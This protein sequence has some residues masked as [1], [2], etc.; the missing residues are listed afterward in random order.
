[1]ENVDVAIVGGGM[2]GLSV[3]VA[4]ENSG[5]SVAVISDKPCQRELSEHS[6]L[7]VSAINGANQDTLE[8]LGVW[9]NLDG[10][11][12]SPYQS[13]SVWDKGEFCVTGTG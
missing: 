9:E 10:A 1:M 3:A 7:R 5:L 12:I 11:R 6:E 13:M 8:Q 4:L 2:V